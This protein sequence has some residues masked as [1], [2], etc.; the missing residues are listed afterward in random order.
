MRASQQERTEKRI[1]MV[2]ALFPTRHFSLSD[3][4][5][6]RSFPKRASRPP[7]D[8]VNASGTHSTP[9]LLL[10]FTQPNWDGYGMN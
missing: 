5:P 4:R 2:A 8:F 9:R 7:A 6:P 3:H 10:L 1:D